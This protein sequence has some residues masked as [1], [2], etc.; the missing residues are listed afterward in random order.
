MGEKIKKI[1][2]LIQARM[3]S[4][5]LPNKVLLDLD[6]NSVISQIYNRLLSCR[7]LNQIIVITS[8]NSE[9]DAIELECN[10]NN[11]ICFRGSLE[12]VLDRYYQAAKNYNVDIVV[13]IT[14][15]CPVIDPIIV[16]AVVT[17]HISGDYDYYSLSGQFPDGLDVEVMKFSALENAW[18][19]AKLK[20]EREHVCPYISKNSE[21]FKIGGLE[22][23]RN[24]DHYR[25]TLDQSEDYELL[26]IIYA[27]L[28]KKKNFNTIDILDLFK[29][30]PN[31]ININSE[32]IRNEGYQKSLSEDKLSE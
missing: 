27:R 20:S 10:I 3:S 24:L 9:D 17:G 4:K 5:R 18:H 23:F 30:D 21:K 28:N 11:I 29:N 26:K 32:I 6:G 31:L 14:A 13:R 2:A 8:L 22:L 12:D 15:D 16:D 19:N 25:W 7:T 1:A